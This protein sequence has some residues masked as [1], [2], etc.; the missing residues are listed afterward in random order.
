MPMQAPP[1]HGLEHS[2]TADLY[3]ALANFKDHGSLVNTS[4]AMSPTEK[5]S[6]SSQAGDSVLPTNPQGP[7]PVIQA[8]TEKQV[9]QRPAPGED[10]K[11][12]REAAENMRR[13]L[14]L[15]YIRSRSGIEAKELLYGEVA[16]G[17]C[18]RAHAPQF[19]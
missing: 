18:S 7:R 15:H 2:R 6:A 4:A 10:G 3:N 12:F 11:V 17:T 14:K 1:N 16:S 5:N 19:L 9:A 13:K 8:N